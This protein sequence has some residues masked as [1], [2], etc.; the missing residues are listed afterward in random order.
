MNVIPRCD[1]F[2]VIEVESVEVE[3][4]S[5]IVRAD[6][7]A[8]TIKASEA[9]AL[10][11]ECES[12]LAEAIPALEAAL[13][14]LDTLKV[15]ACQ[16]NELHHSSRFSQLNQ[17]SNLLPVSFQPSDITI[18]KSMKNPP[19]AVKLVMSAVCVMKGIKPDMTAD[20][21]GSGKKVVCLLQCMHC[22]KTLPKLIPA[23]FILQIRGMRRSQIYFLY[24]LGCRILGPKQEIDGRYEFF[25]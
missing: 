12:D 19:S 21:A 4:K 10:K 18:V 15:S 16:P 6:E 1:T 8:A 3:A 22:I 13:S 2:Q 23:K 11:D 5:K 7:E 9:Q 20:P 25:T 17:N 24:F 14:A